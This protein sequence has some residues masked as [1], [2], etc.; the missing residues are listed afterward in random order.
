MYP[1]PDGQFKV[2]ERLG[3]EKW[4][5]SAERQGINNHGAE[6]SAEVPRFYR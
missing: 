5:K 3:F 1:L 2:V 6:E 4:E